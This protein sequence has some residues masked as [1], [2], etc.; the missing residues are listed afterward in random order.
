MVT[1]RLRAFGVHAL[2]RRPQ[3][4]SAE[5]T[6]FGASQQRFGQC[7]GCGGEPA[8]CWPFVAQL[9]E[10]NVAQARKNSRAIPTTPAGTTARTA[11]SLCFPQISNFDAAFFRRARSHSAPFCPLGP[12]LL[13]RSGF[14]FLLLTASFSA[15]RRRLLPRSA[16]LR[17]AHYV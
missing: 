17:T 2:Q 16:L 9:A 11:S 15:R 5:A 12:I 6:A 13:H 7:G 14:V 1:Y 8:R 3:L 4:S 10:A